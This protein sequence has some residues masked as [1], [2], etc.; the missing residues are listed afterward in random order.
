MSDQ[1]RIRKVS[2]SDRLTKSHVVHSSSSSRFVILVSLV[3]IFGS[4]SGYLS[5]IDKIVIFFSLFFSISLPYLMIFQS[6]KHQ[7][8]GET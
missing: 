7:M 5:I 3:N 6:E 1:E 2:G 8:C 4:K